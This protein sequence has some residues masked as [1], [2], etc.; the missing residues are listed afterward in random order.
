MKPLENTLFLFSILVVK[1]GRNDGRGRIFFGSK[2]NLP[3]KKNTHLFDL[4]SHECARFGYLCDFIN[5]VSER[6]GVL[7]VLFHLVHVAQ[8]NV[9]EEEDFV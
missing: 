2:A 6:D 8:R 3:V 7:I 1:E 4:V 9:E 5:A